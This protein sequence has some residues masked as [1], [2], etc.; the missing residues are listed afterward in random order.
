MNCNAFYTFAYRIAEVT[1]YDSF[2]QNTEKKNSMTFQFKKEKKR[3]TCACS[4]VSPSITTT[5]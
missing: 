2:I 5:F 3:P 4:H 1:F